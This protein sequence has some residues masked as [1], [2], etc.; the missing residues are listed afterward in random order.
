MKF[1]KILY[2]AITL[3]TFPLYANSTAPDESALSLDQLEIIA[4]A[5]PETAGAAPAPAA[6][7]PRGNDV[8][9]AYKSFYGNADTAFDAASAVRL[10][11]FKVLLVPGFLSDVKPGQF[12]IPFLHPAS[13]TCFV[14]QMDW[15]RSMGIAYERLNMKSESSVQINGAI[16]AAAIKA[17]EKPVIIIA[18]SKGGLD[19][20]E[21]LRADRS[22]LTKVRGVITLQSPFFGT[23]LADYVNTN[24]F[25]RN[26][27]GRL[28]L[29][30][31]GN[32][33]SM[34]NLTEKD[35]K[36]YMAAN[37][38][39][40]A[41]ITSAVPVVS[42]AAFK[43]P[44]DGKWDTNLK[45][46]RDKM[47]ENGIHSDG[48]VPEESAVLPGADI[49]RLEGFDHSVTVRPSNRI[50]LDRVRFTK[51]LLLTLFAK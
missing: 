17:S 16:I 3:A 23:P 39:A 30:M 8:T 4:P 29:K 10:N 45:P 44:V 18:H 40:I 25:L 2:I 28:L 20:L 21:A 41:G 37:A 1:K 35:R 34:L 11:D 24:S 13:D 42:V 47:F 22:L 36:Q 19:T 9:A 26:Y 31:G 5:I 38:E 43:D 12:H 32:K 14:E 48:I 6:V 15:L 46:L 51:A 27:A 49:V 33:E 50:A 7:N